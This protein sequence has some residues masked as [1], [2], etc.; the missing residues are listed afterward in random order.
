MEVEHLGNG[1]VGCRF[2]EEV[3]GDTAR[4]EGTV[5]GA[6]VQVCGEPQGIFRVRT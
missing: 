6:H 5:G 3:P 1:P 4:A 2:T